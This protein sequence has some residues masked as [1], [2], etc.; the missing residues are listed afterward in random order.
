MKEIT[1]AVKTTSLALLGQA[2]GIACHIT[3]PEKGQSVV[4][5]TGVAV[6]RIDEERK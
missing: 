2:G 4:Q 1:F 5:S 3:I 6:M